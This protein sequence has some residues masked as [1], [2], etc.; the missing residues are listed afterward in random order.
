M[1]DKGDPCTSASPE[2]DRQL[3]VDLGP[4]SVTAPLGHEPTLRLLSE[5]TTPRAPLDV[6]STTN[7]RERTGGP[8]GRLLEHPREAGALEVVDVAIHVRHLLVAHSG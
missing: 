8:P 1:D 5:D 7:T 4:L 3:R 2:H 6:G